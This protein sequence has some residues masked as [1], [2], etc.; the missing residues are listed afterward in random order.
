MFKVG[1]SYLS[2][3]V[4]NK[5]PSNL[6]EFIISKFGEQLYRMFFKSYTEKVWKKPVN[7]SVEWGAQ[8][9]KGLSIRKILL[10]ILKII[11]NKIL[12]EKV[13]SYHKKILKLH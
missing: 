4:K 1:T 6:E 3:K 8:R 12:W 10:D 9:I 11:F 2:S 5:K 7:I 13:K